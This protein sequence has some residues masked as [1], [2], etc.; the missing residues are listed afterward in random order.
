MMKEWKRPEALSGKTI[1]MDTMCGQIYIT[2]NHDET[3]RI[4]EVF[5]ELGKSGTCASANSQALG[6]LVSIGLQ[7]GTELAKL[8]KTLKGIKC[9]NNGSGPIS[10]PTAIALAMEQEEARL[11]EMRATV[12]A[13]GSRDEEADVL[14]G[15]NPVGSESG[16]T[17]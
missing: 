14:F 16:A 12:L 11:E 15:S 3:G 9:G 10:C 4:V 1:A 17:A 8:V 7:D 13:N 6:R 5:G 2:I